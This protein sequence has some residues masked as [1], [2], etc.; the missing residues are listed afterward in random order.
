MQNHE[1]KMKKM[2]RKV[3]KRNKI[4]KELGNKIWKSKKIPSR[5]VLLENIVKKLVLNKYSVVLH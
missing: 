3:K 4:N 1:K 2:I 5:W